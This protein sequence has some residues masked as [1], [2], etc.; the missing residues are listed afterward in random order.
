MGLKSLLTQIEKKASEHSEQAIIELINICMANGWK[1]IIWDKLKS[2]K[3]A[4][5]PKTTLVEESW[6]NYD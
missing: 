5:D 3:P 4:E 1:G 2:N 6:C